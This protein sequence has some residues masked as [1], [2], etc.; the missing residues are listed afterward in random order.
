MS[1]QLPSPPFPIHSRAPK[2]ENRTRVDV[3]IIDIGSQ[4]RRIAI[5]HTRTPDRIQI[6]NIQIRRF[7][8]VI[9]EDG[10]LAL[11]IGGLG[12]TALRGE[13][14]LDRGYSRGEDGLL[15]L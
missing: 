14:R 1:F 9:D 12:G 4:L 13:R 8:G 6:I 15:V 5:R 2:K 3:I 7:S 10:G 11:G